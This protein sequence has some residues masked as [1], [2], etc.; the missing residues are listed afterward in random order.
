MEEYTNNQFSTQKRFLQKITCLTWILQLRKY[1]DICSSFDRI[2]RHLNTFNHVSISKFDAI[3]C[4]SLCL[5]DVDFISSLN[6]Y[7]C[8][9]LRQSN[10]R[11]EPMSGLRTRPRSSIS[12]LYVWNTFSMRQGLWFDASQFWYFLLQKYR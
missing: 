9:L 11:Q 10:R 2:K 3:K 5:N 4:S 12:W 8:C 1:C 6:Y 7:I